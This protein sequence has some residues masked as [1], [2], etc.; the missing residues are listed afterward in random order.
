MI[1][2]VIQSLAI[3]SV[4]I[5]ITREKREWN[6]ETGMLLILKFPSLAALE[7]VKMTTPGAASD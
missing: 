4:Q 7:V 2:F 5:G 6:T 3:R 1:L